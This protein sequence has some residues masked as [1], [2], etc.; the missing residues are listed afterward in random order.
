MSN[1]TSGMTGSVAPL[2]R[3]EQFSRTL[4]FKNN[5]STIFQQFLVARFEDLHAAFYPHCHW[6]IPDFNWQQWRGERAQFRSPEAL[7]ATRTG[8][9]E[10]CINIS[11]IWTD[12]TGF[13]QVMSEVMPDLDLYYWRGG[14]YSARYFSNEHLHALKKLGLAASKP[15]PTGKETRDDYALVIVSNGPADIAFRKIIASGV[16]ERLH[17]AVPDPRKRPEPISPRTGRIRRVMT[18]ASKTTGVCPDCGGSHV[19]LWGRPK[20]DA[21]CGPC[22]RQAGIIRFLV[23]DSLLRTNQVPGAAA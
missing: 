5:A 9:G 14:L 13:L 6:P 18:N 1:R 12:P 10:I 15:G 22:Y 21:I 16:F 11:L 20:S 4:E 19:K 17:T 8:P 23:A 3:Q 2:T 7:G